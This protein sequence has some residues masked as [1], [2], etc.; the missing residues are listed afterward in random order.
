MTSLQLNYNKSFD[1]IHEYQEF[2]SQ[3]KIKSL[4]ET[5]KKLKFDFDALKNDSTQSEVIKKDS[6]FLLNNFKQIREREK[7]I[8]TCFFVKYSRKATLQKKFNRKIKLFSKPSSLLQMKSIKLMI[9]RN[10][11]T[12][13]ESNGVILM[14]KPFSKI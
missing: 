2:K 12:I 14:K 4:P 10:W 5:I 3:N 7:G 9:K 8:L 11:E 6:K 13:P 1:N